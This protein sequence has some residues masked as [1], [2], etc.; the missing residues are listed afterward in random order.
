MKYDATGLR[1]E[2]ASAEEA[3]EFH[4]EVTALI[5]L[6][7]V[8]ATRAVED[9]EQAKGLSRDVMKEYRAVMRA[10]NALRSGLPRKEF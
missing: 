4:L 6:A 5:R 8:E 10:L 7:M 3:K 1:L 2:F 9:P